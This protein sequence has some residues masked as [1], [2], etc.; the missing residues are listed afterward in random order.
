MNNRNYDKFR[1][2][3]RTGQTVTIVS[4]RTPL[5][6]HILVGLF[7]SGIMLILMSLFHP[8]S[9]RD[10]A[11]EILT[12]PVPPQHEAA[13]KIT[14][15]NN[16]TDYNT[17]Q[18]T[19]VALPEKHLLLEENTLPTKI[20]VKDPRTQSP[21]TL[22][23]EINLRKGDNLTTVFKRY[24]LNAT[25]LQ[26]I[27][28]LPHGGTLARSLKPGHTLRLL[29][30]N[31]NQLSKMMYEID[32]DQTLIITRIS[33]QFK[34]EMRHKDFRE[35]FSLISGTIKGSLQK[36]LRQAHLS[37]SQWGELTKIFAELVNFRRDIRMG[38]QFQILYKK[39]RYN[40]N[41]I[42]SGGIV[43][44]RLKTA[45]NSYT[46]IYYTDKN[47]KNGRYYTPDGY[48]LEK[49]FLRVP[50]RFKRVSSPFDLS[51]RHPIL[52]IRRPHEG[53]DL[54]ADYGTPIYAIGDG[55]ISY[56]GRNGGYGKMV[57]L[58]HQRGVTTIYAHMSRYAKK[59][60]NGGAVKKGQVIGY[61]GSTG[62]AT[63]PHLH[64]EYR[65]HGAPKNPLTV[66]LPS[67]KRIP[68]SYRSRFH[69]HS[70]QMLAQFDNGH[71]QYMN[72]ARAN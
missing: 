54:T 45:K 46:A 28:T 43:A 21:N 15:D 9:S 40:D 22:W 64:Y 32:A 55:Y 72:L 11:S 62:L 31:Q 2:Q 68:A 52:K 20:E 59:L 42:R 65:I 4:S 14:A 19:A 1:K 12:I 35:E 39:Y 23:H 10:N 5:I 26:Q 56:V 41:S 44:A 30:D 25:T 3:L 29:L 34:S 24:H 53:V 61:V 60:R 67:G 51:R 7:G 70:G 36:T 38:D 18:Q 57:E 33:K 63:G 50:V 58:D 6:R 48:S 27:K 66:K 71:Q 49:S 37:E 13:E 8:F 47:G 16:T 17:D 69:E